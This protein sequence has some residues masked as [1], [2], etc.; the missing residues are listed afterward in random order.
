MELGALLAVFAGAE[1]LDVCVFDMETVAGG[2]FLE[3]GQRRVDL[4][5]RA[6]VLADDHLA[7]V[8]FADMRAAD[9][10]VDAGD[11]VNQAVL[12]QKLQGAVS[13][14]RLAV[15]EGGHNVV[16]SQRLVTLPDDAQYLAAGIGEAEIMRGAVGLGFLHCRGFAGGVVVASA[17]GHG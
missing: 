5:H 10:G 17:V 9:V 15:A 7:G 12:L 16:S 13:D 14:G 1:D 6:A 2:V 11:V 4:G 8:G 3:L